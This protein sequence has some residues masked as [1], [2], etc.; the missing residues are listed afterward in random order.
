MTRITVA[1]CTWN[2]AR[3]LDRTLARLR[4][5]CIP[6]G[7][8]WELLV[9]NNNSTDET[10]K[11][12]DRHA[13]HL[14]LRRL[15]ESKPGKANAANRAAAEAR[16]ELILWTDDDVLVDRGWL[17]AYAGAAAR[18][19]CLGAAAGFVSVIRLN[20]ILILVP[21]AAGGFRPGRRPPQTGLLARRHRRF[22]DVNCAAIPETFF[23]VWHNLF[24]RGRLA[25]V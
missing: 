12:L 7:I 19:L 15:V 10:E 17:A 14:P 13:G 1:V 16:G 3:L 25:A 20:G 24:E 22:V 21:A 8:D 23:T 11:V 9:V 18:W 2:R 6:D 5:L 4:E